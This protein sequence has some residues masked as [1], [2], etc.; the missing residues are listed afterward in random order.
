[1]E[2]QTSE[3]TKFIIEHGYELGVIQELQGRLNGV[4][5]AI[6]KLGEGDT[7]IRVST[8]KPN[9]VKTESSQSQSFTNYQDICAEEKDAFF[10]SLTH[11][12]SLI[13]SNK[14]FDEWADFFNDPVIAKAILDRLIF[15]C[16]IFNLTGEGYR[17]HHRQT[18]L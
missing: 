13:T 5:Y 3:A 2:K 8:N 12:L 4:E 6:Q 1:M 16:E 15:K 10:T 14:G 9:S 11:W 17:I 18:I 7:T